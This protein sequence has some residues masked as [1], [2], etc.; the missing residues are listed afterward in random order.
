MS[1]D[2]FSGIHKS[3]P[4]DDLPKGHL[5]RFEN[6]LNSL[7]E[8][9]SRFRLIQ[10]MAIAASVAAFIMLSI[11]V[12]LNLEELKNRKTALYEISPEFH[13]TELFLTGKVQEKMEILRSSN[14]YD[15]DIRKDIREIDKSC[16]EVK[17]E[18]IRNPQDD[19]LISA[20]IETYR[21]KLDMLDEVISKIGEKNI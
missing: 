10:H 21:I 12:T 6:R 20:V 13:E 4:E 19:R 5:K 16:A 8:I 2:I 9:Q 3:V 15:K 11:V 7:S 14:S 1:S 18:L 17:K